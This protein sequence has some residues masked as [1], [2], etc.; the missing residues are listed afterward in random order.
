[1]LWIIN[2][3]QVWE[4]KIS[5]CIQVSKKSQQEKVETMKLD[6]KCKINMTAVM[7]KPHMAD[8][9]TLR[10]LYPKKENRTHGHI[11]YSWYIHRS[12]EC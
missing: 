9:C 11:K 4:D 6:N 7:T 12:S 10:D 5:K 2:L 1:M 8:I 3:F